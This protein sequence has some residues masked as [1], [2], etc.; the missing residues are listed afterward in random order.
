MN[1]NKNQKET[2]IEKSKDKFLLQ[3]VDFKSAQKK[4]QIGPFFSC[5]NFECINGH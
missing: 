5:V 1:Y 3:V 4:F 2:F